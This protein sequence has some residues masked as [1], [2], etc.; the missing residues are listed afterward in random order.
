M[1]APFSKDGTVMRWDA[2]VVFG[3]ALGYRCAAADVVSFSDAYWGTG[4]GSMPFPLTLGGSV[5]TEVRRWKDGGF[6]IGGG[7]DTAGAV[8]RHYA[9]HD[10]VVILTDEQASSNTFV[11]RAIPAHVPLYTWNLAGY[12]AGHATG[13]DANRHA[14]GGLTD[15]GFKMIPLLE[16]GQDA[17]WPWEISAS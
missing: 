1:N 17:G 12:R 10:R 11:D 6:F 15:A 8:S 16:R 4:R 14:F 2:A 7:T 3:I 5:L 13:S 9:G